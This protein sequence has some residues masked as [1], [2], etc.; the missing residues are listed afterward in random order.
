MGPLPSPPFWKKVAAR[1]PVA[2]QTPPMIEAVATPIMA[3]P[4]TQWLEVKTVGTWMSGHACFVSA[5]SAEFASGGEARRS[6]PEATVA[7]VLGAE[8]LADTLHMLR[9]TPD[10]TSARLVPLPSARLVPL[11]TPAARMSTRAAAPDVLLTLPVVASTAAAAMPEALAAPGALLTLSARTSAMMVSPTWS[12]PSSWSAAVKRGLNV[13]SAERGRKPESARP[14]VAFSSKPLLPLL[15]L[16]HSAK[17]SATACRVLLPR[18]WPFI[19][20]SFGALLPPTSSNGG[21]GAGGAA[22]APASRRS[23]AGS[24]GGALCSTGARELAS[25]T[26]PASFAAAFTGAEA[27]LSHSSEVCGVLA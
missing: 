20:A 21:D 16:P 26:I 13:G 27:R 5:S 2:R 14:R 18:P 12:A 8:A 22:S 4:T 24:I 1:K 9:F 17:N 3:T 10:L 11:L 25:S 7:G 15:A 19:G 23:S 6:S